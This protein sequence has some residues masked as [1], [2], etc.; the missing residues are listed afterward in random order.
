MEN[1]RNALGTAASG[2]ANVI[3]STLPGGPATNCKSCMTPLEVIVKTR[4]CVNPTCP[5]TLARHDRTRCTFC[6]DGNITYRSPT[7]AHCNS[8]DAQFPVNAPVLG[9]NG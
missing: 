4:Y 7:D 9:D 8:C 6:G 5:E 1:P 3:I 2:P